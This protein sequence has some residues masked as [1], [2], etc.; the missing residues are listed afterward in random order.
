[1]SIKY[2]MSYLAENWVLG[3]SVSLVICVAGYLL[4]SILLVRSCRKIGYDVGVSGMI[5]IW[6]IVVLLKRLVRGS[7]IKKA[8]N[9]DVVSPDEVI[10]F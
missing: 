4:Y 6:N 1:M 5:P 10:E 7:N 9:S 3:Y 2:I 8:E